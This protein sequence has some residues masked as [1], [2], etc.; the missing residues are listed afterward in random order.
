MSEVV[1]IELFPPDWDA[2]K[3]PVYINILICVWE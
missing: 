2:S 3:K 1:Y